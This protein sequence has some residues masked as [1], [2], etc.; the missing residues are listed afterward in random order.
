MKRIQQRQQLVLLREE[1]RVERLRCREAVA[2]VRRR[3]GAVVR[4][5]VLGSAAA[6]RADV[7]VPAA[8]LLLRRLLDVGVEGPLQERL[9]GRELVAREPEIDGRRRVVLALLLVL[10]AVVDG[11]HHLQV[12]GPWYRDP[13]VVR[14]RCDDVVL[15]EERRRRPEGL[16][17]A[18]PAR[19]LLGG[20]AGQQPQ[21]GVVG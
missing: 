17:P 6:A 5:V 1:E 3:A 20:A 16:V 19:A 13:D 4:V 14:D 2:L 8:G 11:A 21:F 12:A 7:E 9:D 15:L 18:V 10:L